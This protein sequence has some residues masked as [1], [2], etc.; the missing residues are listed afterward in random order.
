MSPRGLFHVSAKT[1]YIA[2][3][4]TLLIIAF[5]VIRLIQALV[6]AYPEI[7]PVKV[8]AWSSSVLD[9]QPGS[10]I[11]LGFELMND[12]GLPATLID[13]G[14][15]VA[16]GSPYGEDIVI[17]DGVPLRASGGGLPATSGDIERYGIDHSGKPRRLSPGER[18][19]GFIN[20]RYKGGSYSPLPLPAVFRIEATYRY[21][22]L[23]FHVVYPYVFTVV[24]ISKED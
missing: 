18:V 3:A 8:S 19:G 17:L 22:G 23:T 7:G 13:V 2:A 10:V 20:I 14:A 5:L 9:A 11:H 12:S 24:P 16:P 15:V 21:R 6:A 1:I 4:V